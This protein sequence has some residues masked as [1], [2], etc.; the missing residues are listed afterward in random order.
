MLPA[1]LHNAIFPQPLAAAGG[2]P[3]SVVSKSRSI[4]ARA[5][6]LGTQEPPLPN[7]DFE[8]PSRTA[9]SSLSAWLRILGT[10]QAEP[11]RSLTCRLSSLKSPPSFPTTWSK[12]TGWTRYTKN[13]PESVPYPDENAI[14]LDIENMWHISPYAMLATA[15]SEN[16]WY[17]W[18]SPELASLLAQSESPPQD[19]DQTVFK[20]LI[21]LGLSPSEPRVVV[22]HNV[23]YDRARVLEEYK[24]EANAVAWIDTL[25][26]H[27]A[28][29]GLS[30]QQR[31]SW[32][33]FKKAET[34][35]EELKDFASSDENFEEMH[36]KLMEKVDDVLELKKSWMDYGSMNSL[37]HVAALYLGKEISKDAR[38]IFES[39]S[40]RDVVANFDS[41]MTYCANDVS[42][43]Q[44]VLAHVFPQFEQKC[45]HPISFAGMIEMGRGIL[46]T[47]DAWDEYIANSEDACEKQLE[48]IENTIME[49]ATKAVS[50]QKNEEWKNDEWLRRMDWTPT[51]K[52]ARILPGYPKWY[53]ELW[54]S[55]SK[56]IKVSSSKRVVPYLL[57][58]TWRGYPLY[59][60]RSFGW[61]YVV[62][63]DEVET[64]GIKEPESTLPLAEDDKGYDPVALEEC[65]SYAF[66]KIPHKDGDEANCGN[67]LAK[68][69][70]SAFEAGLLGSA[71]SSANEI[72]TKKSQ[73][74]YWISARERI[75]SQ[76][77]VSPKD[78]PGLSP[79]LDSDGK[80]GKIILPQTV[81]MGTVTRRAVEST[82]L[83]AA[84]AKKNRIGSELKTLVRAPQGYSFVGADVDSEE[85]WICSLF[86]DAQFGIHGAT[87]LGFMTLQGT[88]AKGTDL[89]TVTGNIVGISR[90]VAKIFNYSRFYGAG[91]KHS[92]QL[93]M[94]H[95]PGMQLQEASQKIKKLFEQ[96]KGKKYRGEPFAG[97][98][99]GGTESFTFNAMERVANS[100][101]PRTPVL[102]CSIPNSLLPEHVKSEYQTSRVNWVVQSSGVDYLHILLVS[103]NYLL[104]RFKV[105]GRFM[106]SIHDEVRYLVATEHA[107]LAALALQI[108]NLWTRALFSIRVGINSLPLNVAFFSA[109]DIDHCLR[110][111][112]D[113]VCVTP[114]NP[115][116]IP[117][118]RVQSIYDTI[119]ELND[120]TDGKLSTL[121]GEEL[122]S[123]IKAAET[124]EKGED[125]GILLL[126]EIEPSRSNIPQETWLDF[127]MCQNKSEVSK[128]IDTLNT[129]KKAHSVP[130]DQGKRESRKIS[131]VAAAK[132]RGEIGLNTKSS[133]SSH[134][135]KRLVGESGQA[136]TPKQ[137]ARFLK[138]STFLSVKLSPETSHGNDDN[139]VTH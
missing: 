33:K 64:A 54:D 41:L 101:L 106:L 91:A 11:Y 62:P 6:L 67:P 66:F 130:L 39:G 82:W 84:N 27:C 57:K 100:A 93:L 135:Q 30:S 45:P 35:A 112:V 58:L 90:D 32:L 134:S 7:P 128:V 71:Y 73:C 74:S 86:G 5:N 121:Y 96:T 113:Q 94:Q 138:K 89:H 56:A 75:K 131:K 12:T 87:P 37:K 92:T 43:T 29:G 3:S 102:G 23:A 99:F 25:S 76:L 72:L 103:M 61:M 17:S 22:G 63:R 136:G 42:V 110:K 83:T 117:K 59:Y 81:V 104:R 114:T 132:S 52:R 127:Q 15:M 24:I 125:E 109:V 48:F 20:T 80:F 122:Q 116:P 8:L 9:P 118:G 19:I 139:G 77:V 2:S 115:T 21:P 105:E 44:Q 49:L 78:H 126:Q 34:K 38:A 60:N 88:K 10:E 50:L 97:S 65:Y 14:V 55:P 47:T 95:S 36:E 124:I 4:L 137:A 53:R 31:N 119:R 28:V 108:S 111:E 51:S 26:L 107:S 69:Y 98:W 123:V 70:I 46:P 16:Y 13:G 85:L 18:V 68:S 129:R 79:L 133:E 1:A 40:V 120:I